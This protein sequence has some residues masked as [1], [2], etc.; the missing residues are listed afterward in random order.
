MANAPSRKARTVLFVEDDPDIAFVVKFM[1]EREDYAVTYACDGREAEVALAGDPPDIAV[2]DV[3]LPFM[4][5][6]EIL[7]KIRTRAGWTDVPVILLTARSQ[8]ADIV[9]GL[10]AGASDY[11]VK[12]FQPEELLARV[13][14]LVRRGS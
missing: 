10:D 11:V 8:E 14:R 13:R 2:L 5:G 4:D 3:M 6:L 7:R 12:P 1:L 9:R